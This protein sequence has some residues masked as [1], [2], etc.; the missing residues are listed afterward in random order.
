MTT[1]EKQVVTLNVHS[2]VISQLI[3][4]PGCTHPRV[5]L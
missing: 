5:E 4:A 1:Y 2:M 3:L